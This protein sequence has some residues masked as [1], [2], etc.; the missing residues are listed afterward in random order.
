MIPTAIAPDAVKAAGWRDHGLLVVALDDPRLG[1][2]D[3]ELV[4]T[5]GDKL[6]GTQEGQ[7]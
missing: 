3:R 7:R 5:I 4:R 1:W 6:Y 2:A